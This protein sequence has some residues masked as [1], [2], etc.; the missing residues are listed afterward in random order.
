ML[1]QQDDQLAQLSDHLNVSSVL[2]WPVV[3]AGGAL[4][5]VTEGR[6]RLSRHRPFI[7]LQQKSWPALAA[8]PAIWHRPWR[9]G[10]RHWGASP[11]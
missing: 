11:Q 2:M 4:R 7:D 6:W 1:P 8:N 9:L 3:F 5:P 10:L